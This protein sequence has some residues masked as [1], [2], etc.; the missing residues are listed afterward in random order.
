[1]QLLRAPA[2]AALVACASLSPAFA[3]TSPPAPEAAA[4]APPRP[5]RPQR[6]AAKP[7]DAK[8]AEQLKRVEVYGRA[9][10]ESMRRAS[11]A[12]KIII[13]REEIDR[14]GDST[15]GEVIKRLP[16]VT[17][18]GR[19][20]RGGEIRM[21]GMGGGYTQILV[22]GE[23]M[24]PGFSLDQLPP[25][26]VERIEVLRAPT[27]E[28]GARAIAGT[29]NIVLREALQ[30]HD[31]DLRLQLSEERGKLRPNLGW[32]RNDKF[33]QTGAYNITLNA[34]RNERI[35][36]FNNT[37]TTHLLATGEDNTTVNHGRSNSANESLNLNA[38]VQWR[39]P[40]GDSFALQPFIVIN[41]SSGNNAFDQT[42]SACSGD[43]ASQIRC[44]N[45]D[46]ADTESRN[47]SA[48]GRL[49]GQWQHRISDSTRLE[50][51]GAL[52]RMDGHGHSHRE[53][54]QDGVLFRSQDD[55]TDNRH[56]SWS[57]AAKL[58]HQMGN[59]HSLV[60]GLEAEGQ[61][62]DQTRVTLQNGHPLPAL[63]DFGDNLSASTQRYAY[64]AQ[65]EWSV[66][67]Q[68]GFYAGLRG[69]TIATASS[70]A[71]NPVNNRSSVW[72]P[73]L[74]AVWK[75]GENSRDQVRASLTRSY[76]SPNLQDMIARPSINSQYACP[77]N[78]PC[79]ANVINYADRMGNPD[80][81]PEVA[82]GL[83]LAYENYLSLGGILSVN[84]FYRRIQDLIRVEPELETVSWA[85][86]P[87]WVARPRNIGDATT[88]G[89]ELE[90]KFRL[91]QFLPGAL[92]VNIRSNLSLFRSHVNQI[93]GPHNTLDQQ[94][95]G[96]A[97]LGFDYRLRSL[98]L[99]LGGNL[100]Y[101]PA[102]EIQQTELQLTDLDKKRVADA[103]ALWTF[104]PTLALRVSAA[105]LAPLDYFTGS[106]ITTNTAVITSRSGGPSYTQWQM[107]L[108]MKL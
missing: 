85:S 77:D 16:G 49:H 43:P 42:Q 18:G 53:E 98:P 57:M 1:M 12:S 78:A 97:N 76:R 62:L 39:E 29:I 73:L 48:M 33:G 51:R 26:Q 70:S 22:N 102:Y 99:T 11:T 25:D 106:V 101:T 15:L 90:A 50:L 7:D 10:D 55:T 56:D 72:T 93:P 82:R 21:R 66:G 87:R 58:S 64:Y 9:S 107:R 46:H 36:D 45:Y 44:L 19:P 89:V 52:G 71:G 108:E 23:R 41:R 84:A 79:G 37:S 14:Y 54:R 104:S 67:K 34:T 96:T 100:N 60:G 27:A 59:E 86:V 17:T 5:A 81:K 4:S 20:G 8:A 103:F 47:H 94:P 68:W 95:R 32:T 2:A 30:K 74:H 31:N 24:P 91:D 3:Q 61:D 69:E 13:T 28:Y 63:Q 92:P 35:D 38:R 83:E 105:N 65:D 6:P 88:Y 40:G 80:L 75:L